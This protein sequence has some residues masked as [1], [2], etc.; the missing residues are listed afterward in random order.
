MRKTQIVR[1]EDK[2][3]CYNYSQPGMW[4]ES[5][6]EG[7]LSKKDLSESKKE[8]TDQKRMIDN[9]LKASEIRQFR[10]KANLSQKEA[11][12]LFGGGPMAFSKYERGQIMQSRSTDILMRLIITRKISISDIREIGRGR[13]SLHRELLL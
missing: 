10:K 7:F 9:L 5:C 11:G 4:C 12:E 3:K 2:G 13:V 1:A 6:D 8:R